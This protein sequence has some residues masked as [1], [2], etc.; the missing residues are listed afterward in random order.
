MRWL[1]WQLVVTLFYPQAYAGLCELYHGRRQVVSTAGTGSQGRLLHEEQGLRL[2]LPRATG[3]GCTFIVARSLFGS[4]QLTMCAQKRPGLG[5]SGSGQPV[6]P[7]QE[8]ES[9]DNSISLSQH[10]G[11]TLS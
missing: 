4:I 6:F 2:R 3:W 11:R 9:E 7:E 5:R 10:Y 8:W 1:L